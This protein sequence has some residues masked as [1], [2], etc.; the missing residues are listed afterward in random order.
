VQAGH[1]HVAIVVVQPGQ[2]PHQHRERVGHHTAP[3]PG[4]QTVVQGGT[5]TTQ[6]A[7]PR[8][9]TVSA[10]TSGVQLSESAMTMT[11]AASLSRCAASSAPSDGEPDS[12]SPSTNTVTPTGGLPPVR[13]ERR[14]V[15]GDAGLVVGCRG[16]TADRRVRSART[17]ANPT[18]QDHLRAAS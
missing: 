16:R 15:C 11:S 3:Q 13:P 10:G 17:A 2:Q 14:Q 9:D 7:R 1:G 18:A 6:S 12:S 4:M 8:S 5:S